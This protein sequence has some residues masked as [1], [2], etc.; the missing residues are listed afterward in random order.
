MRND[1]LKRHISLRHSNVTS[2]LYHGRVHQQ[3]GNLTI[4]DQYLKE[5]Q[6]EES[7][8]SH[9]LRENYGENLKFELHRDNKV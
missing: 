6:A 5:V 8:E 2:T 1:V 7:G 3:N 4:D 9:C